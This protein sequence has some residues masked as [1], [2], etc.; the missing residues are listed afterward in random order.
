M[1]VS[2]PDESSIAVEEIFLNFSQS[3]KLLRI[4]K[5]FGQTTQAIDTEILYFSAPPKCL[6]PVV[7]LLQKER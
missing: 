5:I 4:Y 6:V 1:R 3:V 2:T 7:V